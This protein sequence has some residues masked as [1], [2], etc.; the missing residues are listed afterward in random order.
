MIPAFEREAKLIGDDDIAD[1]SAFAR[2]PGIHGMVKA[3]D[4]Q[5]DFAKRIKARVRKISSVKTHLSYSS[6]VR[7]FGEEMIDDTNCIENLFEQLTKICRPK[8]TLRPENVGMRKVETSA[9]MIKIH[10]SLAKVF[11]APLRAREF[12][13]L[14]EYQQQHQQYQQHPDYKKEEE[15]QLK[16]AKPEVTIEMALEDLSHL[17]GPVSRAHTKRVSSSTDPDI[18]QLLELPLPPNSMDGFTQENL[19]AYN[20]VLAL[21]IFDQDQYQRRFLGRY[22][23][24]WSTLYNSKGKIKGLFRVSR[25]AVILGYRSTQ[26]YPGTHGSPGVTSPQGAQSVFSPQGAQSAFSSQGT[27]SSRDVEGVTEQTRLVQRRKVKRSLDPEELYVRLDVT[28]DPVLQPPVT[29]SPQIIKGKEPNIILKHVSKWMESFKYQKDKKVI[30]VA[31][32]MDGRSRLICRFIRPQRPPAHINPE[33][34]FAIEGA[35]RYVSMI[36]FLQDSDM[37][38]ELEDVWCTDQEFL[39]IQCGD[40]EE[41]AILLCNY[42]NYIDRYKRDKVHGYGPFNVQSFCVL[43]DTLPE[44]KVMMVLRRDMGDEQGRIGHCEFWDAVSGACYFVP[45]HEKPKHG[46]LQKLSL[47]S[48]NTALDENFQPTPCI[49]IQRIH[50]AFNADNV[51][52]NLQKPNPNK[53]EAG[54]L[55]LDFDFDNTRNWKPLFAKGREEM[56]LRSSPELGKGSPVRRSSLTG[57]QRTPSYQPTLSGRSSLGS[58]SS[59]DVV[60]SKTSHELED[61]SQALKYLPVENSIANA[62]NAANIEKTLEDYL[63]QKIQDY[64]SLYLYL[65]TIL[66]SGQKIARD[67]YGLLELLEKRENSRRRSGNEA[68]FPLRSQAPSDPSPE[69][70]LRRIEDE[71]AIAGKQVFG[72]PVNQ[73]YEL[74]DFRHLWEAIRDTRILE[75]GGERAEYIIKVRVFDYESRI[76]SVWVFIACVT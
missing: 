5:I 71:C 47:R 60:D 23:L 44:G 51:W 34:P 37:F 54:I 13:K 7:E 42:F 10:V 61:P 4:A 55:D 33:S 68:D 76:K 6:I 41:H 20:G 36:P 40:W 17:N 70:T 52:A 16:Q 21:N 64:R 27:Q 8:R 28:V 30:A 73:P 14:Q 26:D 11:H 43:C 19:R 56:L 62:E 65:T 9:K 25:P 72:V 48:H 57:M 1:I 63:R 49:P 67:L 74:G 46:I 35:A 2:G 66:D 22:V 39:N 58:S 59:S 75:L 45:Y 53:R 32:D 3:T 69:E 29:V 24:P 31:T 18:N 50:V 38:R 15:R 12:R